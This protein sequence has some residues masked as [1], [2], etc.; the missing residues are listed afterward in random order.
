M[1]VQLQLEFRH[2]EHERCPSCDLLRFVTCLGPILPSESCASGVPIL[3][4]IRMAQLL[5]AFAT[6]PL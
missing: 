5:V 4:G 3:D 6:R 1:R 2:H